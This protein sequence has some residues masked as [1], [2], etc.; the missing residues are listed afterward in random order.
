MAVLID[1]DNPQKT[2]LRYQYVGHWTWPEN[3]IATRRGYELSQEATGKVDVIADFSQSGVLPDNLMSGFQRTLRGPQIEFNVC[4][5]VSK[6]GLLVRLLDVYR[7]L[8]RNVGSKLMAA[9]TVE[10]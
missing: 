4:V 3:E 6:T 8:N 2:A 9:S 1:W 7:R 10:E 5:I